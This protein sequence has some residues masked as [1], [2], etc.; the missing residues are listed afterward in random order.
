MLANKQK[1]RQSNGS[2]V[3]NT[4]LSRRT[5]LYSLGAL[6]LSACGGESPAASAGAS[7]RVAAAA[8]LAANDALARAATGETAV[9]TSAAFVHPGLLH[10]QSDFDRMSTKVGARAAP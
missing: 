9:S 10:L 4:T 8:A 6:A 1:S 7:S 3:E 5:F 2:D